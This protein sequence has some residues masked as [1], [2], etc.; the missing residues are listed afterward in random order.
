MLNFRSRSKF[1]MRRR[2]LIILST[3]LLAR[4]NSGG[5]WIFSQLLKLQSNILLRVLEGSR[6]NSYR[7]CCYKLLGSLKIAAWP[8]LCWWRHCGYFVDE[9]RRV[10]M[11]EYGLRGILNNGMKFLLNEDSMTSLMGRIDELNFCLFFN[12][13][14]YFAQWQL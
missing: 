5:L 3:L 12:I 13:H 2:K 1:W 8:D 9:D 10:Q 7:P 14:S 11:S 4:K 6:L